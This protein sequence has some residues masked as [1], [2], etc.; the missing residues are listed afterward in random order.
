MSSEQEL[1]FSMREIYCDMATNHDL[2]IAKTDEYGSGSQL[3]V[4]TKTPLS[5]S[6][7]LKGLEFICFPIPPPDQVPPKYK[8]CLNEDYCF[9]N[10]KK[11]GF[12][13]LGPASLLNVSPVLAYACVC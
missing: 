6:T 8:D 5:S 4:L 13:Q 12:I 10:T 7:V 1:N 11:K 3:M 2:I 9:V